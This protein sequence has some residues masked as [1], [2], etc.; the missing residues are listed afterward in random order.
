MLKVRIVFI[1]FVLI[2]TGCQHRQKTLRNNASGR[3]PQPIVSDSTSILKQIPIV[4]KLFKNNSKTSQYRMMRKNSNTPM[5]QVGMPVV[6]K[7]PSNFI[8]GNSV[9]GLDLAKIDIMRSPNHTS[10]VL[11][12]YLWAGYNNKSIQTSPYIGR[13]A[14]QYEEQTRRIMATLYGYNA[15]SALLH[16]QKELNKSSLVKNIYID[17]YLGKD[18]VKFI[19]ELNQPVKIK[20]FNLKYPGR[21]ILNIY[22]KENVI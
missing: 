22:P 3:V 19:I 14:F 10:L 20:I 21:I 18:T 11:H 2:F 9:N 17:R 16:I 7:N 6:Q 15:V 4:N 1:L 8:G 12:S 5:Q 13:Y